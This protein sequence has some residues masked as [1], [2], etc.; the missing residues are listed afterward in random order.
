MKLSIHPDIKG[1]P[2]QT[3]LG[4]FIDGKKVNLGYGWMNVD[5]TWEDAFELVTTDGYATSSELSCN[6]RKE[7]FFVSRQLFMVDIDDGMSIQELLNDDFYN[8]FAAGFYTT[9][10]HTDEHH[11]FRI[12]FVTEE[13]ITNASDAKKL[14]RGLLTMFSAGD[15]SCK[16]AS[17]LY[18]GVPNSKIKESI[19][20]VLSVEACAELIRM[21]EEIDR[22]AQKTIKTLVQLD[23]VDEEF[24]DYLLSKIE[25]KVGNLRGDYNVWLT[26]AWATCHAV[27]LS[28]AKSLMMKHF[29]E[30]TKKESHAFN[31]WNRSN[32]PTLGTLIKLSGISKDEKRLLELEM[33]LRRIK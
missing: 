16:D 3:E 1:K 17:R 18:Y 8:Q 6:N 29:P 11:R 13:P 22:E 33:K 15:I 4:Y 25:Y 21:I 30:K 32:S 27:G 26:I 28:M 23:T 31:S 10:R 24:V 12:M 2:I 7:E 19:N 20:R 14:T 9:A 5:V